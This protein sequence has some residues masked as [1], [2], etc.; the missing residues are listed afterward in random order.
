[1]GMARRRRRQRSSRRRK[2]VSSLSFEL[3]VT[4]TV[5]MDE[6]SGALVVHWVAICGLGKAK[7]HSA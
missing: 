2:R 6:L 7:K 5:C 3:I 1:M 4:G